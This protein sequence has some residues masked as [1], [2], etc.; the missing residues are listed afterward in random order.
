LTSTRYEKNGGAADLHISHN[1]APELEMQHWWEW[2]GPVMIAQK[3]AAL[4]IGGIAHG[5]DHFN[6]IEV[7][8]ASSGGASR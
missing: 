7:N 5:L 4:V 3:G 1:H 2:I 6:P 8:I